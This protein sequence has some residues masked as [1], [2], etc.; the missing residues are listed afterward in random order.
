M[1][2]E[3]PLETLYFRIVLQIPLQRNTRDR[4]SVDR[5]PF[6][7]VL[8]AIARHADHAFDVVQLR[9]L[10]IAEHGDLATRWGAASAEPAL[11][12]REAQAVCAFA[13]GNVVPDPERGQHRARWDVERLEHE[14]TQR[15][16]SE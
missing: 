12:F 16:L 14:G 2:P 3:R 5:Q 4:L 13:D 9:I 15:H 11:H 10:R 8:D 7:T 6:V 1:A